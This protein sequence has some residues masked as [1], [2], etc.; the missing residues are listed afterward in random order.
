MVG[1]PLG[2]IFTVLFN[3]ADPIFRRGLDDVLRLPID[4]GTLPGRVL[5]SL[6]SAWLAI[7]C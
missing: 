6:A 4:L 5:F 3:S 2:L 7:R 1:I